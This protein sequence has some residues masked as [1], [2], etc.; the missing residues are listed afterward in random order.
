[1]TAPRSCPRIAWWGQTRRVTAVKVPRSPA[2]VWR[3]I[4]PQSNESGAAGRLLAGTPRSVDPTDFVDLSAGSHYRFRQRAKV[5]AAGNRS[6][7]TAPTSRH[8]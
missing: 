6:R 5:V 4:L 7:P 3:Q 8:H 2:P 1:M